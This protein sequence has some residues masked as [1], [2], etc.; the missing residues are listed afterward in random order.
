[1]IDLLIWLHFGYSLWKYTSIGPEYVPIVF[2]LVIVIAIIVQLI[3]I[4]YL[5]LLEGKFEIE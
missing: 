3:H 2:F 5:L 1:M 4:F